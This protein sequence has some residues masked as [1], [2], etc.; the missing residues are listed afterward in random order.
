MSMNSPAGR[1]VRTAMV[2]AQQTP[3]LLLDGPTTYL[4][5]QHRTDVPDLCAELPEQGRTGQP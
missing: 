2:I 3:L 1:R 5:S 4:D